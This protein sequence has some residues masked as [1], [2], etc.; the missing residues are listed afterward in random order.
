M[1]FND[2]AESFAFELVR[3]KDYDAERLK[4]A[5]P[6]APNSAPFSG[7]PIQSPGSAKGSTNRAVKLMLVAQR[8]RLQ[9]SALTFPLET[10]TEPPIEP[11]DTSASISSFPPPFTRG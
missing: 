8:E 2:Q 9:R 4:T 11:P 5:P 6:K 3:L 10:T 7:W 1:H